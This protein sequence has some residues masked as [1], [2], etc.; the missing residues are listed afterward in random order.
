MSKAIVLLGDLGMDHQGFPP[1][2]VI[3]GSPDVIVDGKPVARVGDP[4]QP[5]SKPKHPPHP[6]AIAA[7]SG[8]VM[9]NGKP[10]AVTGG[11]VSC[12]GVTVGSGTVII[13][14]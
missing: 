14:S 4:L 3:A 5:H 11:A 13:G 6:R 12:G 2:P 10:A 7:G 9:I 8:T 1:T